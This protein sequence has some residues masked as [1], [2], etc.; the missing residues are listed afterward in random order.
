MARLRI[1]VLRF[2]NGLVVTT[3][4]EFAAAFEPEQVLPVFRDGRLARWLEDT[5]RTELA[6]AV[7]GIAAEADD[8]E[9]VRQLGVVFGCEGVVEGWATARELNAE[10]EAVNGDEPSKWPIESTEAPA[11]EAIL[12]KDDGHVGDASDSP[13]AS[14]E[15]ASGEFEVWHDIRQ[16]PGSVRGALESSWGIAIRAIHANGA[17]YRYRVRSSGRIVGNYFGL[18]GLQERVLGVHRHG[19]RVLVRAEDGKLRV[20]EAASR[21]RDLRLIP[22]CVAAAFGP[23]DGWVTVI[24][25][26]Q[27]LI[28][29][30]NSDILVLRRPCREPMAVATHPDKYQVAVSSKIGL[31]RVERHRVNQAGDFITFTSP[32]MSR[33]AFTTLA[34]TPNGDRIIGADSDG[35]LACW[36]NDLS[37]RFWNIGSRH[38]P[39]L[40]VTPGQDG[41]HGAAI[42]A[43]GRQI[44][45]FDLGTGALEV[46]YD[47]RSDSAPASAIT[48]GPRGLLVTGHGDGRVQLWEDLS[49]G[50][51]ALLAPNGPGAGSP[52]THLTIA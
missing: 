26:E 46:E 29:E 36:S 41:R 16:L 17:S 33:C 51:S 6:L 10:R 21:T 39:V 22:D 19:G 13:D 27:V 50:S 14:S 18:F 32:V 3:L 35:N 48:F 38:G 23:R 43:G 4:E 12:R 37:R 20:V 8:V 47:L 24:T 11:R 44:L 9:V 34:F 52:V 30:E 28:L 2:D 42:V 40:A 49:V 1:R 31:G 15:S 5:E 25:G 45:V 7:A